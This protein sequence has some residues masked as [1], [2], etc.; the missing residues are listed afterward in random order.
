V[1][2]DDLADILISKLNFQVTGADVENVCRRALTSR[3]RERL[4]LED[5][6]MGDTES[7]QDIKIGNKNFLEALE[8]C[9]PSVSQSVLQ[10]EERRSSSTRE[11]A[12]FEWT[13]AFSGGISINSG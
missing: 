8:E 9:Y 11:A 7:E 5:S 6:S 10:S 12:P 2:A 4:T 13:G 1:C 3:I